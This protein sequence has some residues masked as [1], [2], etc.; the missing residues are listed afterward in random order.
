MNGFNGTVMAYGQT[1]AGKS[2]TLFGPDGDYENR[3]ICARAITSVFRH[4]SRQGLRDRASVGIS[5]LECYNEGLFDMLAPPADSLGRPRWESGLGAHEHTSRRRQPGPDKAGGEAESGSGGGSG[6]EL[7]IQEDGD[8]VATVRDLAVLPAGTEEDAQSHLYEAAANRTLAAHAMNARSSR[9]HF[10]FTIHLTVRGGGDDDDEVVVSK[11]HM[12]DLAGSER[13][14]ATGATG[15]VAREAAF[16]NKSLSALEQVVLAL[17]QQSQQRGAARGG[18]GALGASAAAGGVFHVPF[19]RTKLTHLLKDSLGGN[20]RTALVACLWPASGP[21]QEQ[22]LA[23]LKFAARMRSVTTRP[24]V[25]RR[26]ARGGS[27]PG[28]LGGAGAEGLSASAGGGFGAGVELERLR[29]QVNFPA[30]SAPPPPPPLPN[31]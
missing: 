31:T 26:R 7:V 30:G 3:G 18:S 1:G 15:L 11:L 20:C 25:N 19:R 8:G 12:V 2:H 13:A 29:K 5:A 14:K 24:V 22:T 17:A 10:V 21:Q 6:G 27:A 16:I 28:G 9:A 23:T 4:I